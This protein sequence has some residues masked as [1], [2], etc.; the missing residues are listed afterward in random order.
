MCRERERTY[1]WKC[2]S[3]NESIRLNC[4]V[5]NAAASFIT[6]CLPTW[7]VV[8]GWCGI[9]R[10][11]A[12]FTLNYVKL[13]KLQFAKADSI[14]KTQEEKTTLHYYA[15]QRETS[16]S[17]LCVSWPHSISK[18]QS[19]NLICA[20][21]VSMMRGR[22]EEVKTLGGRHMCLATLV[23]FIGYTPRTQQR[24]KPKPYFRYTLPNDGLDKRR[25]DFST[26]EMSLSIRIRRRMGNIIIP[27]SCMRCYWIMFG[28]W[29]TKWI[30]VSWCGFWLV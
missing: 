13:L 18:E 8:W 2:T 5:T 30:A 27:V 9:K 1:L 28:T 7:W 16:S 24:Y 26:M 10:L 11:R 23:V 22:R 19:I 21:R 12:G 17:S 6:W 20:C 15:L 4:W 14:P 3:P 29:C 25:V